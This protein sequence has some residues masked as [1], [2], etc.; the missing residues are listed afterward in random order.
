MA[1]GHQCNLH[2]QF[3][4]FFNFNC[5]HIFLSSVTTQHNRTARRVWVYAIPFFRT[6]A[7]KLKS[8]AHASIWGILRTTELFY[9]KVQ[10]D[11][12]CVICF[13]FCL[14]DM[15]NPYQYYFA[16]GFWAAQIHYAVTWQPLDAG[17]AFL[18]SRFNSAINI[19]I[20][21][22]SFSCI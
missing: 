21:Q 7:W 6:F 8:L 4:L 14:V 12:L 3:V 10:Y 5:W 20:T 22:K 13:V 15:Y 9:F 16:T 19:F 11:G 17:K 18:G 2:H 1:E